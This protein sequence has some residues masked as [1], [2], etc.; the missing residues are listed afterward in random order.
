MNCGRVTVL[1]GQAGKG[2]TGVT[3]LE[4][5]HDLAPEA[6]LYFATGNGGEAQLAA[7]IEALCDAGADVIVGGTLNCGNPPF[8]TISWPGRS[9]QLSPMDASTFSAAGDFGN[10]NDGSSAVWEGD[11]AA[12]TPLSV[13]GM[14]VG[15]R[16]DFGG[17]VEENRITRD[18]YYEFTLQWADPL[19]ASANDY[20]LFLV[21][22]DGRSSPARPIPKMARRTRLRSSIPAG[23]TIRMP[24]SS[25]SRFRG[26]IATCVSV[27]TTGSWR[28]RPPA[29]P[30]G[31]WQRENA[32]TVAA[33]GIRQSGSYAPAYD[34]TE[35]VRWHS[36]GGPRRIFYQADGT[37]ITPGN[38]SSSGGKLL[39][40]SRT[41]RRL[42]E[43]MSFMSTC[44]QLRR[45]LRRMREG[46]PA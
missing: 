7:N 36:A 31:T 33:V 3:L 41:L 22:E 26:R 39:Q 38:F 15:V 16:H 40:R 8:R 2:T 44:S 1:P 25:S 42:M 29:A 24:V 4:I 28:L 37:P 45:V 32:V 20:D 12:G 46:L 30:S 14:Q 43:S 17:G 9:M 13:N 35:S 5:V 19:G 34:G 10:L 6:E 18:S 21:N 23:S 11:F 27:P